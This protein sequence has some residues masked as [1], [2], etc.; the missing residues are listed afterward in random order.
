MK[1]KKGFFKMCHKYPYSCDADISVKTAVIRSEL[2]KYKSEGYD[3]I[4]TNA[5]FDGGYILDPENMLLLK[6]AVKFCKEI[7][8]RVWIYDEKYYPS[9]AAGTLTLKAV[10]EAEAK[11]LAAVYKV[12]KPGE[13]TFIP[14][15]R[16]HIEAL[17]AFG[18]FFEG[19]ALT[20]KELAQTPV[21]ITEKENG[22]EF[23]N[24]S[25]K[26]LLCLAFFTKPAFEGTHCQH[27]A[28][29]VRRYIDIADP[30]AAK[31][32]IDNTYRPYY[33]LLKEYF[34]DGTVEAFFFDEPSFMATYFNILK[35]PREITHLP[36]PSLPLWASVHWTRALPEKFEE[37]FGYDLKNELF[38]LFVGGSPR[39]RK[40]R[41]DYYELLTLLAEENFFKPIASFCEEH[42]VFS[43]GHLLLEERITDHPRFEGNYFT[44]LRN[45]HIP[46]MDMLDSLPE[47][48]RAKA[49]TPLLLS[50]VSRLYADGDVMD[51]VS[52]HFQNKFGTKFT[53]KQLFNSLVMQ[54]CLGANI[55]HSYYD[56]NVPS[57]PLLDKTG[58]G[59]S[60]I[61]AFKRTVAQVGQ[62]KEPEAVIHYPIEAINSVTTSPPDAARVFDSTLNESLLRY[63]IDRGEIGKEPPERLIADPC[64]DE[65]KRIEKSAD[66][67][68]N[69]LLDR[70]IPPGFCD[71]GSVERLKNP[72]LFIIPAQDPPEELIENLRSL[73]DR[74][75]EVIAL[76]DG[77]K[78]RD[79]YEKVKDRITLL[80]GADKLGKY[81]DEKA[82]GFT[83][84][85]TKGVVALSDGKKTLF[86][87]S[88]NA[89][90][91][92]LVKTKLFSL[93]DCFT[94]AKVGFEN[95]GEKSLF[96]LE[97]YGVY[98]AE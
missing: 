84:G 9:G 56:L 16:G 52:A 45:Q 3:G 72:G 78:F 18:F 88:E 70:Q 74:G 54:Y 57:S 65:S 92:I 21:R 2:E 43:S 50:S 61:A 5:A 58:S 33:D 60:V 38:R 82:I 7:G 31:R 69:A 53:P 89:E 14:L 24:G 15:P 51:E 36:D 41:R 46:G 47:R 71:T 97:P 91:K 10:P 96:T 75:F 37:R 30:A 83:E 17:A 79:R 95:D 40:V 42:S 59:E 23:Y 35:K 22:F 25:E 19:N 63:P 68:M 67:C 34:D 32:F 73:V 62:E 90:K 13:R 87:N 27:N 86:V 81:L 20:E 48:V 66:D 39:D 6:E 76:T 1:L 12:L 49:F 80:D 44:L 26:N 64:Y 55:F 29:A 94:L 98:I 28:A 11:A 77:A 85:E 93:T 4:V 8:L